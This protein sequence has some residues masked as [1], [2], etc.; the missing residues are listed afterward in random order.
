MRK[1][2]LELNALQTPPALD[3]VL[4]YPKDKRLERPWQ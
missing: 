2:K 1:V 3:Y 4:R